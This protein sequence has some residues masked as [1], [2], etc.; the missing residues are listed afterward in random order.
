MSPATAGLDLQRGR[1]GRFFLALLVMALAWAAVEMV[2]R[3]VT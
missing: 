3:Q 1:R 2:A